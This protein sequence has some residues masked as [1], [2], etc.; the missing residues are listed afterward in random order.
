MFTFTVR[1]WQCDRFPKWLQ[2]TYHIE[3]MDFCEMEW[4]YKFLN[5][6]PVC[7]DAILPTVVFY[8]KSDKAGSSQYLCTFNMNDAHD[9]DLSELCP[10]L[11]SLL[12]QKDEG[13]ERLIYF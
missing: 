7:N 9:G 2:K 4:N 13:N 5:S 12:N 3:G 6:K 8:D 10:D 11:S 1:T